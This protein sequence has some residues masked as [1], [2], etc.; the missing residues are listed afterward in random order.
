MGAQLSLGDFSIVQMS[1]HLQGE[2]NSESAI[3]KM[4]ANGKK[5]NRIYSVDGVDQARDFTPTYYKEP[6]MYGGEPYYCPNG[7][8]RFSLDVGL[9]GEQF[10]QK[11][12]DWP[13]AFHGTSNRAAKDIIMNGFQACNNQAC[14]IDASEK[15]VFLTPSIK[16]AGHPRYA[17]VQVFNRF[18]VQIV[19]QVRVKNTG[20]M[21]KPGTVENTFSEND[22]LDSNFKD[23]NE[24]EW[25][26]LW[27][28]DR[29][30]CAAD[31]IIVYGVMARITETNPR[32]LPD[33]QWWEESRVRLKW[34]NY[35]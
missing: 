27:K 21:K 34:D 18:Y 5:F 2:C 23:N 19:L 9:T 32:H 31:G 3:H 11:Y 22:C 26:F 25:V 30:I 12:K 6:V 29:K 17:K 13:V 1:T 16:Y 24:L 28:K 14:F 8:R 33:N 10:D 35:E 20:I 15:A 7:W 4:L